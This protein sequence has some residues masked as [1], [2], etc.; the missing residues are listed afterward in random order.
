MGW[1]TIKTK[2]RWTANFTAKTVKELS[3]DI[4]NYY[5]STYP[6]LIVLGAWR[7][8]RRRLAAIWL[9]KSPGRPLVDEVLVDLTLEMKR[10][11]LSWE[12]QRISD[13]LGILGFRVSKKT[14]RKILKENGLMPP[15]RKL[16]FTPPSWRALLDS[17]KR[18]W[19]FDFTIVFD[20]MGNQLY[21]MN[22]IDWGTR[23]LIVSSVTVSPDSVW[24]TQQFCN[25][26]IDQFD[27]FPDVIITDNDGIFGHWLEPTLR[28]FGA[29]LLQNPVRC[30]WCNGKTERV[31]KSEKD[32]VLRRI[33]IADE[34]HCA[35]LTALYRSHYNYARPHQGL[36]GEIPSLNKNKDHSASKIEKNSAVNGLIVEFHRRA[37]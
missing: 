4:W 27:Q 9:P 13:E 19:G 1:K 33:P 23:R 30:P 8:L 16:K 15:R 26:S 17:Y 28:E 36:G 14:V 5:F 21:I 25:A 24:L 2:W 6:L 37:A 3:A 7:R 12:C 32:E 18:I 20:V 10:S 22:L 11:N 29:K 31:H 35:E 34:I